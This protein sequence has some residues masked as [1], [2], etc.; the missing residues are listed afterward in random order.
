MRGRILCAAM[1]TV[2]QLR[3]LKTTATQ[4][5]KCMIMRYA[6]LHPCGAL[7]V[8]SMRKRGRYFSRD[9]VFREHIAAYVASKCS[10]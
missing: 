6:Q 1:L 3:V 5:R 4:L 10:V 9:I 7:L 8:H 2:N